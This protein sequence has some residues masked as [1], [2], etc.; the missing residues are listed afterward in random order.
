MFILRVWSLNAYVQG[1]GRSWHD[2]LNCNNHRAA[3][4]C[5]IFSWYSIVQSKY[6]GQFYYF[7][8]ETFQ[9]GCYR[10]GKRQYNMKVHSSLDQLTNG[11]ASSLQILSSLATVNSVVG[12]A[13]D[14]VG[15]DAFR[16]ISALVLAMTLLLSV[17]PYSFTLSVCW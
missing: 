11:Y 4:I 12:N 3:S 6:G 14:I 1:V 8:R 9:H 10:W 7:Y 2:I 17:L 5:T 13:V 16:Y 15:K